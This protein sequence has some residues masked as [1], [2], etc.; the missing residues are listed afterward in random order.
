M[1]NRRATGVLHRELVTM[2]ME[3]RE[4][5]YQL[6]AW[7][8]EEKQ[9][10]PYRRYLVALPK[11]TAVRSAARKNLREQRLMVEQQLRSVLYQL[12][13]RPT[14]LLANSE[15]LRWWWP[16]I[17]NTKLERDMIGFDDHPPQRLAAWGPDLRLVLIRNASS[18]DEV[19]QWYAP[20]KDDG[21]AGFAAGIWRQ[22]D[23]GPGNRVFASTT[24]VPASAGATKRTALKI[25]TGPDWTRSPGKAMWNPR[26]VEITVAGCLSE[27]ALA[28]SGRADV[29]PDDPADWA[30]LAHQLRLVDDYVPLSQPA[31]L[32]WASL[33]EE[34]VLPTVPVS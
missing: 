16:W 19:P 6:E 9:W 31:A 24:D 20:T 32:H 18:R 2:R 7:H 15:N 4:G 11:K 3:P 21:S 23:A 27:S 13:D 5:H 29:A 28:A 10:L 8:D 25:L 14:M 34:Y 1:V 22:R 12:R 26:Y 33:A 17:N 30:A